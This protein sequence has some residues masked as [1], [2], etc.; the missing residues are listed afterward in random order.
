[1]AS[2]ILISFRTSVHSKITYD[3]RTSYRSFLNYLSTC[4]LECSVNSCENKTLAHTSIK[5]LLMVTQDNPLVTKLT[6]INNGETVGTLQLCFNLQTFDDTSFD[7]DIK[8]LKKFGIQNKIFNNSNNKEFY[9]S[10]LFKPR[11]YVRPVSSSSIKTTNRSKEELT[12]DYLMGKLLVFLTTVLVSILLWFLGKDMASDEE[13][14]ALN[15][16]RIMPSAESLVS[17][18]EKIS[19]YSPRLSPSFTPLH[20]EVIN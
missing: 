9:D 5:N 2:I 18:A 8:F 13:E 19:V 10:E 4:T 1:M 16:L 12:S 15:T 6:L 3:I 7:Y 17:A 11:K 14:E 20:V